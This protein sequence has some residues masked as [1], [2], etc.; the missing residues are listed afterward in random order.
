MSNARE[1]LALAYG[2]DLRSQW[3][4]WSNHATAS[5]EAGAGGDAEQALQA[6]AEIAGNLDLA[7]MRWH[8]AFVDARQLLWHGDLGAAKRQARRARDLGVEASEPLAK[9]I[10][11]AQLYLI[12]WD[13]GRLSESADLFASAPLAAYPADRDASIGVICSIGASRGVVRPG[14]APGT[15]STSTPRARR[16]PAVP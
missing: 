9:R 1:D 11:F 13:E 6:G 3:G 8:V 5:M 12:G 7:A 2:L 10:Y 15:V 4:A 16:T 14:M